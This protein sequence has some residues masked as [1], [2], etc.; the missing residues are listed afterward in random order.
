MRTVGVEE[1]LLLVDVVSGDPRSVAAQVLNAPAARSRNADRESRVG[2]SLKHEFQQEQLEADTTP[3]VNML[4]LQVEL[5]SWRDT[6][7]RAARDAGARLVATGTSPLP[8]EPTLTRAR[9]YEQI[10]Q[11]YGL[12]ASQQL[13]CGCHVHVSV[14]SLDEAVGVLDRIREWLPVLVSL[15]A[16]SPFWQGTDSG[17]ASYRTQALQRWPSAGPNEV[18]GT[19]ENY[20]NWMKAMIATGVVMDA[21]MNYADA[22][23]SHRYP[24]VEIRAGDVCLDVRDTVLYAAICR[25]LV[26]TAAQQWAEGVP[27]VAMPTALL[28]LATWQAAHDGL[29]GVLL[30]PFTTSP[31]PA[32]QVV[33][34]LMEHIEPALSSNGDHEL[35]RN[36]METLWARGNGAIRQ[37]AALARTGSLGDMVAELARVTAGQQD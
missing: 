9:R 17:Y 25:A 12:T 14:D 18:F 19:A 33:A 5:R 35:V 37:R 6:A 26:D 8:V 7:I 3:H 4:E 31:R 23:A 10:A 11:R 24:T 20:T 16:N 22:R 1:E 13:T 2:G 30:D 27:P 32:Q 21:G 36:R 34:Q 15:S 28:Q 29:T